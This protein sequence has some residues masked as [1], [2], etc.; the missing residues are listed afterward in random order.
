MSEPIIR[1][2]TRASKLA[3]WQATWTAQA[4]TDLG[5]QVELVA[6]STDGDVLKGPLSEL[7]GDGLFTK[8]LQYALLNDEID[9]AVHSLKDLPTD[10]V[11]GLRLSAVPVRED[12]RDALVCH[13]HATL[14]ELPSGARIG[15]GSLRRAA[16]AKYHRPDFQISDLRGN[17]ETRLRKL[18]E[19]QYDAIILACAGL[20]RLELEDRIQLALPLD[21]MLSAVGQGALGLETRSDDARVH[22]AAA[23]LNDDETWVAVTAE[24]GFLNETRAGC[25]APVAGNATVRDGQVQ[26]EGAIL[27]EDGQQMI[28]RRGQGPAANAEEVG[29]QLAREIMEAGG[30]ALLSG[31]DGTGNETDGN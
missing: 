12:V 29:R 3:M 5:H 16:Q 31:P 13:G 25:T 4:L 28:R 8:R 2:G 14:H 9:L 18:D 10:A 1:L 7:G 23:E 6:L 19:G 21:Q 17:V 11:D 22:Q 26:L 15:T 27:S 24:R 30:R 20:R